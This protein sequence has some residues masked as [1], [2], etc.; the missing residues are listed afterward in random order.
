M[1][2]RKF[3]NGI[4]FFTT[5]QMYEVL[6]GISDKKDLGL[7]EFLRNIIEEYLTS[8]P[9]TGSDQESLNSSS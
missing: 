3:T 2:Q 9:E 4:T 1:K 5:P 8:C 7:S 6:K